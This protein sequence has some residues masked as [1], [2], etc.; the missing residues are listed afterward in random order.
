MTCAE[1]LI[2]NNFGLLLVLVEIIPIFWL[3][4]FPAHKKYSLTVI[5]GETLEVDA[6]SAQ[7]FCGE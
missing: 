3:A 6:R 2:S 7:S 1:H 4:F 5:Y